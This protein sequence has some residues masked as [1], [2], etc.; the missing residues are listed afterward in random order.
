[1]GTSTKIHFER[2]NLEMTPEECSA[3]ILKTLY[4]YL[5]ED[6]RNNSKMGTVI[7]Y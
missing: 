6:I 7:C 5:P 4:G 1:M 3:E 2:D